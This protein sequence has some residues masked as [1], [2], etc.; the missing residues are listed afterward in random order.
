MQQCL[1]SLACMHSV[2][3]FLCVSAI[4]EYGVL[5][6]NSYVYQNMAT[7]NFAYWS[8]GLEGRA[9]DHHRGNGGRGICQQ[10]LPAGP[11]IWTIF[12]N[13]RGMLAARIDSHV[14]LNIGENV[15]MK[16]CFSSIPRRAIQCLCHMFLIFAGTRSN[17]EIEWGGRGLVGHIS[18]SILKGTRHFFLLTII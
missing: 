15:G 5:S 17:F 10:K 7:N 14:I 6:W 13:A 12:S 11:G 8:D 18:D 9:F 2:P 4:Y 3:L 16:P 1:I